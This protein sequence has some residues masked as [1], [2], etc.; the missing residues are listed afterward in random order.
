MDPP[1]SSPH[2]NEQDR[3]PRLR[4]RRA[5][6]EVLAAGWNA[7][8]KNSLAG[9]LGDLPCA[10]PVGPPLSMERRSF[11]MLAGNEPSSCLAKKPM[12]D[13]P[14]R[15]AQACGAD[16]IGVLPNL[17]PEAPSFAQ[18]R[19]AANRSNLAPDFWPA[20][21]DAVIA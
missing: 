15:I 17:E 6:H 5:G 20:I 10:A 1:N 11:D 7:A 13:V 2:L 18:I 3:R 16:H 9:V 21:P 8:F 12:W 14:G 19:S 4:G